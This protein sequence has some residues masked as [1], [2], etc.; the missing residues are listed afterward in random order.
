MFENLNQPYQFN[1]NF[2]HNVKTIL[3]VSM[4]FILI[5]LYIQPLGINFLKSEQDGYFVLGTGFLTAATLFLNTLIFPGLLPKLFNPDKW[6]IKKEIIWN[7][8]M[9]SN[10]FSLFTLMAWFAKTISYTDL[11]YFRTGALSLLPLILFNLISYNLSMKLKLV[12]MIDSGKSWLKEEINAFQHPEEQESVHLVAENKKQAFAEEVERVILI[13]SSGNYV[14][15]YWIDRKQLVR[16]R[17][18]RQSFTNVEKA[19]ESSDVMLKCHRC[20][21]VNIN[22]VTKLKRF[23]N[24]YQLEMDRLDFTVPVSR[25]WVQVFKGKLI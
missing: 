14:E 6:T 9:F 16:K 24:G 25:N 1:N 18:F 23:P 7:I 15:I 11:P 21:M 17:L 10:L 20:W 5:V 8:W 22:K 2:K 12:N 4:G 19:L 13:H 3:L